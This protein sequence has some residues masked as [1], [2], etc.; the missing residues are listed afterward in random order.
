MR[1]T[2]WFTTSEHVPAGDQFVISR[3]GWDEVNGIDGVW[4]IAVKG[5]SMYTVKESDTG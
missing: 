4:N 1:N 2:S 3:R 5:C